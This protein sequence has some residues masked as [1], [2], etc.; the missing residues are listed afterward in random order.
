MDVTADAHTNADDS[1]RDRP[2]ASVQVV[3]VAVFAAHSIARNIVWVSAEAA[4]DE[5]MVPLVVA[6][7]VIVAGNSTP[8]T[9]DEKTK[10]QVKEQTAQPRRRER[11]VK[12][13]AVA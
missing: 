11:T 2:A 6:V 3:G 12:V 10:S 9:G 5:E 4:A 8:K 1:M 13:A 7:V